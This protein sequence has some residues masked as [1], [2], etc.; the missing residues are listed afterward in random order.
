VHFAAGAHQSSRFPGAPPWPS[1]SCS[2]DGTG[3]KGVFSYCRA[4]CEE[5]PRTGTAGIRCLR[6]P[7]SGIHNGGERSTLPGVIG[8]A[9]RADTIAPVDGDHGGTGRL[10][11]LAAKLQRTFCLALYY[12]IAARLPGR[13]PL[14]KLSSRFRALLCRRFVAEAGELINIG[15]HVHLGTGANVR[16]G[17]RSGIGRGSEIHGG[18]TIGDEVMLA[19]HVVVLALNHRFDRLDVPIGRQGDRPLMCPR[20]EDGAWIGLGAIILP[21]RTIGKEAV[22]GAGAVVSSDVAPY[23]IVAGN[24]AQVVGSR[25]RRANGSAPEAAQA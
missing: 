15:S 23:D 24:P 21:G 22:V 10:G 4:L 9:V 20:I 12:G 17:N 11:V 6:K 1:V 25:L 13:P 5:A 7:R 14:A 2:N 18:V 19:P 16:I 8:P 3:F